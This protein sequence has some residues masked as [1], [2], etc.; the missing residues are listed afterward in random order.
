M[1]ALR[2]GVQNWTPLHQTKNI[3]GG[4]LFVFFQNWDA[5]LLSG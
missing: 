2:V 4:D 5:P 3:D 1:Q